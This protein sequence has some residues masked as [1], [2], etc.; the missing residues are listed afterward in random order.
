VSVRSP[1]S[2]QSLPSNKLQDYRTPSPVTKESPA[3]VSSPYTSAKSKCSSTVAKPGAVI[4]A[5]P[6]AS[7]FISMPGL[8]VASPSASVHSTQPAPVA[9]S[10]LQATLP[11]SPARST[12]PS[13]VAKTGKLNVATPP[14][15][16]STHPSPT[17]KVGFVQA[18][19]LCSPVIS[20][21]SS[22][23]VNSEA[24]LV[25][26]PFVSVKSTS[27]EN[28]ETISALLQQNNG[29]AAAPNGSTTN[30]L[31]PTSLLRAE[32]ADRPAQDLHHGRAETPVAKT[33]I[34][35]LID[36]V[37]IKRSF[38][39]VAFHAILQTILH[40]SV[41]LYLSPGVL[42]ITGRA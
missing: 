11:S 23:S 9:M 2:V 36:A 35:R 5:S 15:S 1:G 29:E 33:P 6:S 21:L 39:S 14:A 7:S 10:G 38:T 28:V 26:S 32:A 27:S 3:E 40:N 13:T 24:V 8:K 30:L 42:F 25:T 37:S 19:T 22:M 41:V 20:A 31:M 4:G 34:N 16:V 17:E 12:S 18:A